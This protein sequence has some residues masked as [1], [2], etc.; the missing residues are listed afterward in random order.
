M[1]FISFL[2]WYNTQPI[3]MHISA[4]MGARISSIHFRKAI[5]EEIYF[6]GILDDVVSN[7]DNDSI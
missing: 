4:F 7:N 2:V 6:G 1:F 3:A 5:W